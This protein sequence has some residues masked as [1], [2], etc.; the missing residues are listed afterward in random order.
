MMRE[1]PPADID[2]D[3]GEIRTPFNL[4]DAFW[5]A[6][7]ALQHIR[8][9]AHSRIRCADAVLLFV[10]ARVTCLIPPTLTL[11]AIAG[12]KGSLNFYGCVVSRSGGGKSS[13]KAV[14][15]ELVP[16]D[17]RDDIRD[18]ISPGSGE[19]IAELFLGM[20]TETG[21]DGKQRAVKKQV[22]DAAFFYLDEGAALNEM[23]NRKGATLMPQLRSAWSGESLGQANATQETFRQV[24][25]HHYR[26]SMMVGF[27]L[28]YAADIL[29]D[30]E[31]G[32]PQRFVFTIA[33]DP[34]IPHRSPDWPGP[35]EFPTPPKIIS[36]NTIDFDPEVADEIR[37]RAILAARGEYEPDPLDSHADLVRMKIAAPLAILDGRQHVTT[38][39]WHL[40]GMVLRTSSAVRSWVMEVARQQANEIEAARTETQ[41]RREAILADK[42]TSKAL[43]SGAKSIANKIH[44]DGALKAG[45]IHRIVSSKHRHLVSVDDMITY[46]EDQKW[47]TKDEENEWS[48]GESRPT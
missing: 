38:E 26:L 23:G 7:P 41:A 17:R 43:V 18:D 32:T 13:A 44:R 29:T 48:P 31:G 16:L 14:A 9:A 33:T 40:A 35:L 25:A 19:G 24:L 4:P 11:P 28:K 8:Q 12:G 15:H 2:P 47:I 45:A 39:D 1:P 5:N 21:D 34:A 46:A 42:A 22:R 10:L 27:Q 3:T 30:A 37:T 20:V 36:G 6:R